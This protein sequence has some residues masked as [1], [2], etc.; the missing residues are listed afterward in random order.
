[1]LDDFEFRQRGFVPLC[2]A[3]HRGWAEW[4]N[5]HAKQPSR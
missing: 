3:E 2:L 4:F 1:M 5:R